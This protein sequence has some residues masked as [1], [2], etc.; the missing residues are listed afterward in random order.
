M[1]RETE[2]GITDVNTTIISQERLKITKKK[3]VTGHCGN[4]DFQLEMTLEESMNLDA[5]VQAKV[6]HLS[7]ST[8]ESVYRDLKDVVE[9]LAEEGDVQGFLTL[10]RPYSMWQDARERTFQHFVTAFPDIV[11]RKNLQTL[12]LSHPIKNCSFEISWHFKVVDLY[13]VLPDIQMI[14]H[15]PKNVQDSSSD[16]LKTVPERFQLMLQK[17]GIERTFNCLIAL[18]A[19]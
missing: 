16:L 18:L 13:S 19:K 11:Q 2:I 7:I 14:V 9:K 10:L 17:L 1:S 8:S 4:I 5:T 12:T 6:T 15:I 3:G